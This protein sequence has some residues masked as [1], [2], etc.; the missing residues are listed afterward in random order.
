MEV[1]DDFLDKRFSDELYFDLLN[2]PW[3]AS[4]IANRYT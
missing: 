2:G 1:L 4:N 3:Y